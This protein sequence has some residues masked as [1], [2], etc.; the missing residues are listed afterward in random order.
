MF[1][2]PEKRTEKTVWQGSNL[3]IYFVL[4]TCLLPLLVECGRGRKKRNIFS[5]PHNIHRARG[6]EGILGFSLLLRAQFQSA[7]SVGEHTYFLIK[8]HFH[9]IIFMGLYLVKFY[10]GKLITH[11]CKCVL[12][13]GSS[14][15]LVFA[16]W[17]NLMMMLCTA[18]NIRG[19]G[20][21]VVAT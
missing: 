19:L 16:R 3:H 18:T 8:H 5:M 15:W 7:V 9:G 6:E 11:S 1:R 20:E 10:Y 2:Q 14:V 21:K 17:H 12:P 4:Y 13:R